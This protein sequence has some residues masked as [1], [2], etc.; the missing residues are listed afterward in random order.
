MKQ[1]LILPGEFVPDPR[2]IPPP[3]TQINWRHPITKGLRFAMVPHGPSGY[4]VDLVR[5]QMSKL[6][7][8]GTYVTYF[9]EK[10][11]GCGYAEVAFSNRPDLVFNNPVSGACK[12]KH[13]GSAAYVTP[14]EVGVY[15]SESNNQ[16]WAVQM[17]PNS[18]ARP[19]LALLTWNNVGYATNVLQSSVTTNVTGVWDFGFSNDGTTRRIYLNGKADTST[20]TGVTMAATTSNQFESSGNVGKGMVSYAYIW[21]RVV[22]PWEFREIARNP[23]CFLKL[24]NPVMVDAAAAITWHTSTVK[25]RTA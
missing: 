15:V 14:M 17:R 13:T 1:R 22:L 3:G 2:I 21:N 6:L 25:V 18:D 9:P 24:P 5:N 4:P 8:A 23:W 11:V 10:D 12:F 7:G 19:G 20:T 16:G